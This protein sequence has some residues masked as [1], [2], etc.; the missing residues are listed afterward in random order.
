MRLCNGSVY[1]SEMMR[2]FHGFAGEAAERTAFD[3]IAD[4][5]RRNDQHLR[6]FV[7]RRIGER[8]DDSEQLLHGLAQIPECGVDAMLEVI[9]A[10]HQDNQIK[11][12]V[13]S[14]A[15]GQK[16]LS[17][18]PSL[19]LV[20]KDGGSAAAA[21]LDDAVI[22]AQLALEP[23]GKTILIGVAAAERMGRERIA[24]PV[25]KNVFHVAL[26]LTQ[27]GRAYAAGRA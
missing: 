8:I 16:G 23:P 7:M 14:N 26:R 19:H 5:N 15:G 10:Q 24:V 20:F 12:I 27:S 13:G 1:L 17:V 25:A 22:A 3:I 4:M 6:L 18:P 9:R 11:R 21:L 2:F